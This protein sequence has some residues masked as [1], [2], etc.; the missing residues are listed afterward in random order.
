MV[1]TSVYLYRAGSKY[2]FSIKKISWNKGSSQDNHLLLDNI[3][4]TYLPGVSW[5]KIKPYQ[6]PI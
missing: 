6:I 1:M 3:I 4:Y 5:K 2:M